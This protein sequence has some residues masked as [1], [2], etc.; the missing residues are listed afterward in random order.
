MI[1]TVL[2]EAVMVGIIFL[3]VSIPIMGI[4]RVEYPVDYSKCS[5]IPEN[6]KGKYY[7][8]TFIIGAL[9]HIICEIAGINK[10]YC[11]NGNAAQ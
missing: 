7:V 8:A 2:M 10:W 5:E 9:V 11:K 3:I 6:P 1:S 4:L